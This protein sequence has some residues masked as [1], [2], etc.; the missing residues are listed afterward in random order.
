MQYNEILDEMLKGLDVIQSNDLI[1]HKPL[2]VEVK[3]G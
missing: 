2:C 3:E 1:Q